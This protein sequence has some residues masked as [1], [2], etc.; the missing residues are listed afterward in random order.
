[1]RKKK[2]TLK[3]LSTKEIGGVQ[4]IEECCREIRLGATPCKIGDILKGW[5]NFSD[6]YEEWEVFQINKKNQWRSK[7]R[8]IK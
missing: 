8:R 7:V 6:E 5:N 2:P 4:T 3:E 1:M